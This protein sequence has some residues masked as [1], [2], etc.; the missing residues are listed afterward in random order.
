MACKLV[1][2]F[3]LFHGIW[4]HKEGHNRVLQGCK[5]QASVGGSS[6][7]SS[8]LSVSP[9]THVVEPW[10]KRSQI[11]CSAPQTW[12][13]KWTMQQDLFW[14]DNALP[15]HIPLTVPFRT[16]SNA[17]LAW[18][19]YWCF[20]CCCYLCSSE[21]SSCCQWQ[22]WS[23]LVIPEES[24]PG[25]SPKMLLGEQWFS[26]LSSFAICIAALHLVFSPYHATWE[27]PS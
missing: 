8:M 10:D 16:L 19:P 14:D 7:V 23:S 3:C 4:E 18:D 22:F 15:V 24:I 2:H 6:C 13:I 9:V 1:K 11:F 21:F 27:L 5:V 12:G 25:I 26:Y 20:P 17:T